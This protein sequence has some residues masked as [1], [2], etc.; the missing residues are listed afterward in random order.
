V[1]GGGALG[2]AVLATVAMSRTDDSREGSGGDPAGQL[3]ALTEGF[4]SAFLG[5]A[6][7]A[8]LGLVLTLILI[9][10]SDSR[11]HVELGARA[12]LGGTT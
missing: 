5:G 1:E 12:Q 3:D 7:I 10:N 9:R 6:A 2:L 11:A 8:A 4:Q